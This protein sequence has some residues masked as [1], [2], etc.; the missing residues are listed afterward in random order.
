MVQRFESRSVRLVSLALL[1]VILP[2]IIKKLTCG[3]VV[4]VLDW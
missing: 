2:V 1:Q 3:T 4:M